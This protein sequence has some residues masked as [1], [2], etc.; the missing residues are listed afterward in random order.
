ML[1][2]FIEHIDMGVAVYVQPPTDVIFLCGGKTKP[3]SPQKT[4]IRDAFLKIPD[5][6]AVRGRHVM[7]AETVNTF[8]LSR[9][10]YPELLS[11]EVD[12]AQICEL[13][14]LFSESQGSIAE[15]GAFSMHEELASKLLVVV[16][17]YYMREDSFI[18]LG[19]LRHLQLAHGDHAVFILN[20]DETGIKVNSLKALNLDVLRDRLTPAVEDRFAAVRERTT[21]NPARTGH[22]IKLMVGLIQELGGLTAPEL[23]FLMHPFGAVI[24]EEDIDRLL[25][26]AEA[27]GWIA[28]EQRGF[29]IYYFAVPVPKDALVLKFLKGAPVFNRERRRQI[30]RDHWRQAD[31]PRHN[32][33]IKF[34]GDGA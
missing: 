16:R 30:F 23:R 32:G 4:S 2:P 17:D 26:C 12:F 5:N 9:P 15:L 14:L 31:E 33:I 11:F 6:P 24:E 19:P 13:I 18:K 1:P 21:F 29:T 7:L 10:A 22:L 28:R 34:A 25:L 8:H 27:V 3:K 20:D